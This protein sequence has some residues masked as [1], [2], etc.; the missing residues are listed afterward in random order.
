MES[1][2]FEGRVVR[3]YR[4]GTSEVIEPEPGPPHRIDGFTVGAE[5]VSGPSPHRGELHP[6]GDEFLYVITGRMDVIV[7]DGD[8]DHAGDETV[9]HLGPGDAC[10]VPRA[11]WHRIEV[12]EP[13][14]MVNITPGPHG[15][16][17]PL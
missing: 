12:V 7:D 10:V 4:D 16:H 9:H 11:T 13:G 1:F 17:R 2:A 5:I 6:D 8:Q 14:R 15:G 3:L